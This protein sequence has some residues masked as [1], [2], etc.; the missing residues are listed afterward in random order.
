MT[1]LDVYTFVTD[2]ALYGE[3]RAS[4]AAAGFT[5]SRARFVAISEAEN[6]PY[7]LL[8]DLAAA[9][10]APYVVLCHQDVRLD[11]GHGF[12]HLV[13]VLAQLDAKDPRWAVAGN[14]GGTRELALVRRLAD[15]HG[16]SSGRDWPACVTCLDE[17]FLVVRT[18]TGLGCSPG[19]HGFH[20]YGTDLCLQAAQAAR[21]A[22]VVDFCVRH[23][24][25]GTL[26]RA[27]AEARDRLSDRWNRVYRAHYVRTPNGVL[28]FGRSRLARRTLGSPAMIR[29]LEHSASLGRLAGR[30]SLT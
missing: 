13:A 29:L 21:T 15:P 8:T 19:L 9:A 18:G 11:Q 28:F 1:V 23:L 24:S 22:Y 20:L 5:P 6:D 4:F 12:D 16:G 7:A 26:D 10:P 3:M 30:L 27:W 14:A 2:P 17:N 25:A